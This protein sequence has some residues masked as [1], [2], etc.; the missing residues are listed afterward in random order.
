MVV[1]L[2]GFYPSVE[3]RERGRFTLGPDTGKPA[4][5]LVPLSRRL[6]AGMNPRTPIYLQCWCM[7]NM[8]QEICPKKRQVRRS[9][10]GLEVGQHAGQQH[11]EHQLDVAIHRGLREPGIVVAHHQVARCQT[12][13]PLPED[14][15]HQLE[16]V[17][18]R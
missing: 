5:T 9:R 7:H 14:L 10:T 13:Q 2:P 1:A 6:T 17:L 4:G 15:G 16:V 3:P 12:M 11:I 18:P 8:C